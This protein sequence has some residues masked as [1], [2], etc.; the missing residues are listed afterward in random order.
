MNDTFGGRKQCYELVQYV[1]SI[2]YAGCAFYE[3]KGIIFIKD[4]ANPTSLRQQCIMHY[5]YRYA[6]ITTV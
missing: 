1:Y 3:V 2:L 4:H 5:L 6:S